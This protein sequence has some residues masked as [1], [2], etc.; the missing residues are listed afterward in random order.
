MGI[1]MSAVLGTSIFSKPTK[2]ISA[3]TES[4]IIGNGAF[5]AVQQG[6][7]DFSFILGK[8]IFYAGCASLIVMAAVGTISIDLVLLSYAEK[9][10]D[11]FL[12]GYMLGSMWNSP[13]YDPTAAL[14][15]SPITSVIAT[16]LSFAL[17]V[18]EVGI[19]LMAGWAVAAT[20]VGVGC[21]LV[22]AAEAISPEEPQDRYNFC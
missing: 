9:N 6:V 15:L 18:P 10:H 19:A 1:I 17:G 5:K 2:D 16:G 11:A 22:A 3:V 7:A 14:I 20:L 8:G 4:T 13:S 21:A 12:T